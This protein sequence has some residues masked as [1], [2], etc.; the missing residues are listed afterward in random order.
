MRRLTI[1]TIV[2][3]IAAALPPASAQSPAP[4][5]APN[6]TPEMRAPERAKP[7]A[8]TR[9]DAKD[10][11]ARRCLEFPNDP[12]IIMCAEKFLPRKRNP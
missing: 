1:A 7:P 5:P 3:L 11:D 4:S 10:A 12:Q 2:F 6:A 9:A 8:R